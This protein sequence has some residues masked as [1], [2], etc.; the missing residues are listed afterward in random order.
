MKKILLAVA[1][2][3]LGTVALCAQEGPYGIK[4]GHL[5]SENQT[6][7]GLQYNEVWFDDYGLLQKQHNQIM[8]EGMGNYHTEVLIREGKVY[9]RAWFDEAR[10]DDAKMTEG[11]PD[12]AFQKMSEEELKSHKVERLGTGEVLG[13][14]C[15]IY[16]Y[17][18]KSLLRTVNI[19]VW[20]WE[21]I[22][23]KMETRGPLGANNDMIVTEFVENPRIPASTFDLPA[24][25][26]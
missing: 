2:L 23:L 6:R 13:K 11:I 1:V 10:P 17:K 14:T 3:L 7:G 19:K 20:L 9:T 26:K 22:T 21:G 4:S 5:K 12:L 24:V 25:V 16:A 18:Q 15:T 8:M